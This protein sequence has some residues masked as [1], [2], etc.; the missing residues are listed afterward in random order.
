MHRTT[1]TATLLVAVAVT[2]LSG[3]VTVQ[4]PS[5]SAPPAA[6]AGRTAPHA[7]D[8]E[9]SRIAQAPAREALERVDPSPEP[10]PDTAARHRVTP[11]PRAVAPPAPPRHV[12]PAPR[13]EPR[14]P[15]HRTAV[16]P[17]APVVPKHPDV[18]ALG[19]KYGG[20]NANSPEAVLCAKTYGN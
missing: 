16:P 4:R 3:C 6:P 13:P 20:W 11:P 19:R 14:R 17:A 10:S 18:C 2:A 8:K 15:G 7:D 1:T 9:G 12:H 5:A